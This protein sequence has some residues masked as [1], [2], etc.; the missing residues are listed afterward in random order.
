[1][2]IEPTSAA[3]KADALPL[4]YA[5]APVSAHKGLFCSNPMVGRVGFEPT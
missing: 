5:R 3:W 1:M 4:C 2:G